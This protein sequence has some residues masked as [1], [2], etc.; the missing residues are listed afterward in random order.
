MS[1]AVLL[2]YLVAC[3]VSAS[4]LLVFVLVYQEQAGEALQRWFLL[5]LLNAVGVAA[6]LALQVFQ[7]TEAGT[8]LLRLTLSVKE[9]ATMCNV[10]VAPSFIHAYIGPDRRK[11]ADAV[12]LV[13]ALVGVA[14]SH[15]GLWMAASIILAVA[16][17]YTLIVGAV[18]AWQCRRAVDPVARTLRTIMVTSIA[19]APAILVNIAAGSWFL[20]LP[21][22]ELLTLEIVPLLFIVTSIIL[23][24]RLRPRDWASG[25][26]DGRRFDVLSEREREVVQLLLRGGTNRQIADKLCIAES[27]VKKHVH[28]IFGK[29]EI[30]SRWE[31]VR[32][33]HPP[34]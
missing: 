29:L 23:F 27:T 9:I 31:L 25:T 15:A 13:V 8:D 18:I 21:A 12:A 22:P 2:Y 34:E 1:L 10:F 33:S 11:S 19:F 14:V 17:V 28:A 32:L 4:L 20:S 30:S 7:R 16:I 26:Y 24:V 5:F 3:V 6:T